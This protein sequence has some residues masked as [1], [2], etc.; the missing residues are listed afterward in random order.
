MYPGHRDRRDDYLLALAGIGIGFVVAATLLAWGAGELG[1][2]LIHG[3]WIPL[4]FDSAPP[5]LFGLI[6]HP[7]DPA[8]A[9]PAGVRG[10]VP[11]AP[12]Y[13]AL[14]VVLLLAEVG[15]LWLAAWLWL[16][17]RQAGPT[18]GRREG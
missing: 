1:S 2:L 9:W 11:P 15:V 5:I 6:Q 10:L 4:A 13:Y 3:R 17:Y 14:V 16:R 12:L 7:A 8:A 18:G